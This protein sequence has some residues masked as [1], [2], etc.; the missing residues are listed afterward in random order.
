MLQDASL[1]LVGASL[2]PGI[3]PLRDFRKLKLGNVV[4]VWLPDD[5]QDARQV[6]RYCREHKIYLMLS[7]IVHRHNLSVFKSS[8]VKKV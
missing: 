7:E 6:A 2:G 8:V 3:G 1:P 5:K 4:L